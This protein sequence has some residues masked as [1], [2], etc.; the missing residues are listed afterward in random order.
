[1]CW[2]RIRDGVS[3][4]RYDPGFGN[5]SYVYPGKAWHTYYC[6]TNSEN[7]SI[8]SIA[9]LADQRQLS[10][11]RHGRQKVSGTVNAGW[12]SYTYD[13]APEPAR[14]QGP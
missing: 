9:D 12:M 7:P 5:V 3:R 14:S 2:R 6:Y 4:F 8:G 1:M 11:R 13:A 10:Y